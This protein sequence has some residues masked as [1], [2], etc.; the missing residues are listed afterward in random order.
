MKTKTKIG[1]TATFLVFFSV[2]GC[3]KFL[4]TP[5]DMRTVIDD[6]QKVSELL[7]SAYPRANYITFMES[8]SDNTGDKGPS[9][10]AGTAVNRDPW[11]FQDVQNVSTDSPVNYWYACYRAIAAANQALKVIAE[12]DNPAD[13][14]SQKGE[15]LVARAYAHFMLVTLFARAYD[16]LT[17][18]T[19]PGIPYVT[20]PED[21]VLKKYERHTVSY[22]YD[23]I[24]RDLVEGLPLIDDTRYRVPKY[25]F[26]RAAANAFATR[27][28]LFKQEYEKVIEHANN[29]FSG[30]SIV[31]LIRTVNT[32]AFRS[33]EYYAKQQWHTHFENPANLLLVEAGSI[34][35]RSYASY[36]YGIT[37]PLLGELFF[38]ANVTGGTYA[39]MVYGGTELVYNIPKFREHFV[40]TTINAEYGN[41]YNMIPLFSGDEV[42]LNRAE[43]YAQMGDF[44]RSIEDLNT[45][46]SQKVYVSQNNPVYNPA[47][48][49]ITRAKLRSFYGSDNLKQNLIDATLDFKRREFV[50]EGLR[51]FD[52][53]RHKLP[54]IH[55]TAD[56]RETYVLGPNDPQRLLQLP[57][58]VV[59]AG[60][61][62]NPR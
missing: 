36:R 61:Q 31:S 1:W 56:R 45:F 4:E 5:P 42:L 53:L 15:A 9:A 20:E 25:H 13:Y 46:A 11:M 51:W 48:H 29:V 28:Y 21:A 35:G 32:A 26:T 17:A 27:F 3:Q 44:D 22:V 19:D 24:E 12:A 41:P 2:I 8:L 40:T 14:V 50:H 34:W 43:A 49:T 23:Q 16:P 10:G 30:V 37:T 57:E 6:P 62:A 52:I 18:D 33:M 54:V 55:Q 59:L 58:E 7:T 60:I 39:Y 47:Q 38:G